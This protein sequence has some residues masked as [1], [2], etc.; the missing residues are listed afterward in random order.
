MS[1][2][3]PR[4]LEAGKLTVPLQEPVRAPHHHTAAACSEHAP[5]LRQALHL[6]GRSRKHLVATGLQ[7]H[8]VLRCQVQ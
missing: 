4:R 8:L 7:R 6:L 2:N 5:L 3:Q 1:I